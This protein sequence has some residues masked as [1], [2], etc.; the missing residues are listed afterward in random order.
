M[1]KNIVSLM[2]IFL[3][4]NGAV[5][6]GLAEP[7]LTLTCHDRNALEALYWHD[8]MGLLS[9][10]LAMLNVDYY[11]EVLPKHIKEI[12]DNLTIERSGW[13]SPEMFIGALYVLF[14]ACLAKFLI[15]PEFHK[16]MAGKFSSVDMPDYML[17]NLA[18]V[19]FTDAEKRTLQ[20]IEVKKIYLGYAKYSKRFNYSQEELEKIRLIARQLA[21]KNA[22]IGLFASAMPSAM[23]AAFAGWLFYAASHHGENMN[24]RLN[25]QLECAKQ[26]FE[27]L[28]NE[29]I[30]RSCR[31]RL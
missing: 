18:A 30:S 23:L 1:K 26:L 12:E 19:D 11:L 20:S 25:E 24:K 22:K 15:V 7:I 14:A 29:K 13:T 5:G 27:L 10:K 31:F 17:D 3:V 9:Q 21:N 28:K 2:F 4:F 8:S 6:E 16:F